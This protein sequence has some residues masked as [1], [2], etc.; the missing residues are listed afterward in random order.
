MSILT[1]K[2]LFPEVK[3]SSL[4]NNKDLE[5]SDYVDARGFSNLFYWDK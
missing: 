4:D 5:L 2:T 1:R 3:F